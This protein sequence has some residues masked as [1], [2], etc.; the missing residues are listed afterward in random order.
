M[1]KTVLTFGVISGLILVGMMAL[2]IPL[3]M[4]GTIG[5][6]N[7]Q[8]LGYASMVISF[9]MVFVGIRSYRDNVGGGTITFGKAFQVGI[10]ITV[11]S[12]AM[13]V[14]AWEIY[15][16][17]FAPDFLD[18]YGAYSLAKLR[19]EGATDA[20]IAKAVAKMAEFKTLYAN[21]LVNI[22]LTF[23]EAFPVGLVVTLVCAAI[24][25]RKSAP[26]GPAGAAVAA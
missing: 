5:F 9:V 15:Y 16:F 19:A 2:T 26:D 6:E 14:L 3:W 1:K 4:N 10:L 13:Y 11:I 8:L 21:P 23:L 12:C 22:G 18:K 24:L 20:A 7:S 17:N 25:R